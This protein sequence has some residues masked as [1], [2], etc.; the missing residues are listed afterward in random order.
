M[1]QIGI[2]VE[3]T[4]SARS[5][6]EPQSESDGS[7]PPHSDTQ[8]KTAAGVSQG[9]AAPLQSL[10]TSYHRCTTRTPTEWCTN[11]GPP[12]MHM[13]CAS[14]AHSRLYKFSLLRS[15]CMSGEPG[16][17]VACFYDVNVSAKLAM[18][19]VAAQIC[20]IFRQRLCPFL[21]LSRPNLKCCLCLIPDTKFTINQKLTTTFNASPNS[22]TI[23]NHK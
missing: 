1:L 3:L 9:Y 5:R 18:R 16:L 11:P 6:D 17:L 7:P 12:L 19:D 23:T 4:T 13:S 20:I 14:A 10:C 21:D 15:Q 22:I 8:I 2:P